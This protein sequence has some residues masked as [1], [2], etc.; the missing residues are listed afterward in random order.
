VGL[1]AIVPAANFQALSKTEFHENEVGREVS[2]TVES[3]SEDRSRPV[4]AGIE[5]AI[6]VEPGLDERGEEEFGACSVSAEDGDS[7]I[8]EDA[9]GEDSASGI[10]IAAS[11]TCSQG[12]G[13]DKVADES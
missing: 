13:E 2:T 6:P 8:E 12:I 11:E 3:D 9:G 10:C 7:W 4:G 5:S 1:G